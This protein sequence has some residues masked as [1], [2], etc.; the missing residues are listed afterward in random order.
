MFQSESDCLPTR[1]IVTA[2][3]LFG[4]QGTPVGTSAVCHSWLGSF[5]TIRLLLA[6]R[7]GTSRRG[8][9]AAL[10]HQAQHSLAVHHKTLLAVHPPR[11]PAI[12]IG[13]LGPQAS[14]MLPSSRRSA[15]GRCGFRL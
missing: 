10:A 12:A 9:Q 3:A 2:I 15:R 14:T 11:H 4:E 5:A 8:Q 13:Q 7:T 1:V 6:T